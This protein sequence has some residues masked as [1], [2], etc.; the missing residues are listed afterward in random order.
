VPH[1]ATVSETQ[2]W[3]NLFRGAV[4]AFKNPQSHRD[5]RLNTVDA[6]GQLLTVNLLISKLKADFPEQFKTEDEL[7]STTRKRR[8]RRSPTP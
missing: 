8:P 6:A 4:G 2:A 1:G 7:H 5:V 3:A